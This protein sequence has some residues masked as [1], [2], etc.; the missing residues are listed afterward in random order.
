MLAQR[1]KSPAPRTPKT[2]VFDGTFSDI[3][4]PSPPPPN[5][6]KNRS[7]K[8]AQGGCSPQKKGKRPQKASVSS[9]AQR[10]CL[11]QVNLL[12]PLLKIDQQGKTKRS[13]GQK[14]GFEQLFSVDSFKGAACQSFGPGVGDHPRSHDA[15][16]GQQPQLRG[17]V[18]AARRWIQLGCC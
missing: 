4:S 1:N 11:E 5:Q 10:T 13:K 6:K 18:L 15:V 16:S 9:I 14:V 12:G 8:I 3:P 2:T 17:Q 7:L